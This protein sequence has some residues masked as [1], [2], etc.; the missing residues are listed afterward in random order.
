MSKGVLESV[1]RFQVE[2]N[3]H[4]KTDFHGVQGAT[5]SNFKERKEVGPG[6]GGKSVRFGHK[7]LSC[8]NC[9]HE[10][11]NKHRILIWPKIVQRLGGEGLRVLGE[12]VF[13]HNKKSRP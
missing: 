6:R 3:I 7:C 9:F 2:F 13:F 8:E 11:K 1:A 10:H 4:R 12:S 5:I